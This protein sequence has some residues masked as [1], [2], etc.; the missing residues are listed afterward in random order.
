LRTVSAASSIGIESI[1]AC[2]PAIADTS[3]CHAAG[4][5]GS[6]RNLP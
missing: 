3:A 4:N 6:R 1:T 2:D 5:A